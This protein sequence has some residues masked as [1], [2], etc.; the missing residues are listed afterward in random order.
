ME[1]L[2]EESRV[3]L[4]LLPLVVIELAG[5]VTALVSLSRTPREE[6]RGQ[7]RVLWGVLIVAVSAVGW[8][9]WFLAGRKPETRSG[10]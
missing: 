6:V 4:L 3:V 5:K 1:A 8:I 10:A 7:S 2:S 9:A